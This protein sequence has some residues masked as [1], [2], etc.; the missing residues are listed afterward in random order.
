MVGNHFF[1]FSGID[2]SAQ[3]SSHEMT[4]P[5][6]VSALKSQVLSLLNSLF[7]WCGVVWG[8][9]AQSVAMFTWAQINWNKGL[10]RIKMLHVNTSCGRLWSVMAHLERNFIPRE[11]GCLC[12]SLFCPVS[13]TH[14]FDH[15]FLVGLKLSLLRMYALCSQ[16]GEVHGLFLSALLWTVHRLPWWLGHLHYHRE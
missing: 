9:Y 1:V 5:N 14:L 10:I 15:V 3:T 12:W 6:D 7:F 8:T 4:I 11:R 2:A 16:D 13:C